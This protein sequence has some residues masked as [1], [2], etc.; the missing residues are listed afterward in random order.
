MSYDI[1]ILNNGNLLPVG[2]LE[3][4]INAEIYEV[5]NDQYTADIQIAENKFPSFLHYPNLVEMDGDFFIIAGV[6]KK[7]DRSKEIRLM[8]E[9]VSYVLN[10]PSEAPFFS[11]GEEEFY[12]GSP[13]NII[14]ECWGMDGFQIIDLAGG[15]YYYRPSA[16]G[17]RSRINEFARQNGLEVEYNKFLITILNRRGANKGLVLEVG[18]NIQ[19]ITQKIDLNDNFSIE[20]AHEV[21]IIDFSKMS[22]SQQQA[23]ASADLG[24]TVRM[25]DTDLAIDA[26]ERI[27]G[28][29]YNPLFKEVPQ[30]DVGQVIRDIVSVMNEDKEDE[31]KEDPSLNYFLQSW[32][33]GKINCMALS[34]IELGEEDTLPKNISTSIDFYISGEHKGMSLKVKPQYANYHVI[35]GEFYEDDT[36]EEYTLANVVNAIKDWHFP[37]PKMVGISI[38]ISEVPLNQLN[39]EVHKFRDYAVKFEKKYIEPLQEFKIGKKNVLGMN[40]LIDTGGENLE[41]DDISTKL[42]YNLMQEHKG[43]K[44]SLKREFKDFITYITLLDENGLP[45]QYDLEIVKDQIGKWNFPRPDAEYVLI[46]IQEKAEANF[47]PAIHKRVMYGVTFEKV[48]IDPFYEFRIGDVNCL[49]LSGIDLGTK[50]SLNEIQAEI[51]YTELKEYNGLRL[52]LRREYRSY[53][54]EI[55]IFDKNGLPEVYYLEDVK[56]SIANWSFPTNN[57]M[58][59]VVT[60]SEAPPGLFDPTQ[61]RKQTYG[62]KFTERSD[63]PDLPPSIGYYIESEIVKASNTGAQ[64][65]FTVPYDDVIS[66]SLGVGKVEQTEPVTSYWSLIKDDDNKCIGV[67][68]DIKGLSSGEVEVSIQAVCQE[69]VMEEEGELNG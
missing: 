31:E 69:G 12:E 66:V 52:T 46:T 34:G 16:K 7:R 23:I 35:I 5:I 62:L 19:T 30:L 26:T 21:D 10:D 38:T 15:Y 1:K 61:H 50:P 13:L 60:A 20:Y 4:V 36:Y 24:D 53:S 68:V 9:H 63:E 49:Q 22:G 3:N 40:P 42:E 14:S 32:Q 51:F 45:V 47:N 8:L 37:K 33:I 56:G 11:E 44:L 55:V 57:I 2:T 64:F 58:F 6:D 65:D 54:V 17:G 48:P 59:L 25:I 29:R 18:K 43:M 27:V 28:K 39:P 67:S 41:L